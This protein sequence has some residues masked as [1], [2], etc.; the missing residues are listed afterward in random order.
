MA[1]DKLS[2]CI[3]TV[4]AGGYCCVCRD[5]ITSMDDVSQ[6]SCCYLTL[7]NSCWG[8]LCEGDDDDDEWKCKDCQKTHDLACSMVTISSRVEFWKGGKYS[9]GEHCDSTRQTTVLVEE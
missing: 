8:E 4:L 5:P 2:M 1:D 9:D 3:P 7:C 6:P